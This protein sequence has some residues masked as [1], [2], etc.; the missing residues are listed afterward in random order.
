MRLLKLE[1]QGFG[2][3]KDYNEITFPE[4]IVGIVGQYDGNELQSNGSGKSTLIMAVIY[5]LFGEGEY[6]RLEELVN[7]HSDVKEMFV[8][9]HFSMNEI[10]YF[11]ERGRK[12]SSSYLDFKENGI[13]LGDNIKTTES[14]II[15]VVGMDYKMFTASVF[16]EQDKLDKFINVEPEER[17]SYVDKIL[18]LEIWRKLSKATK[19]DQK[20]LKDSIITIHANIAKLENKIKELLEKTKTRQSIENQIN[21]FKVEKDTAQK[22]MSEYKIYL[23]KASSLDTLRKEYQ[24]L[25]SDLNQITKNIL[26]CS[27]TKEKT[28]IECSELKEKIN[29]IVS[30]S[31]IENKIKSLLVDL[32]G[33]QTELKV[34]ENELAQKWET[35]LLHKNEIKILIQNRDSLVEGTC[36]TCFQSISKEYVHTK[37]DQ[38]QQSIDEASPVLEVQEKEYTLLSDKKMNL[39]NDI[40]S[41]QTSIDTLKKEQQDVE[42]QAINY[43]ASMSIYLNEISLIT[44]QLDS[45][46]EEELKLQSKVD[47]IK[48]EIETLQKELPEEMPSDEELLAKETLIKS[49]EEKI[50][51]LNQDLGELNQIEKEITFLNQEIDSAKSE[52]KQYEEDVESIS[53]LSD[54]FQEIPR[55]L[56]EQ[57]IQIIEESSNEMINQVFPHISVKIYEE[58]STKL[59]RLVVAF[60]VDGK[61]RNYKRLSGGEKAVVNIGLRLGFSK[62]IRLKS[63]TNI[64]FIV[65]DEPFGFLDEHNKN[66]IAKILNIV[67]DWFDQIIVISHVDKVQDFPKVINVRKNIEDVSYVVQ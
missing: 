61:E 18:D 66:L 28:E 8:R 60:D 27:D 35:I 59:K 2:S 3:Y 11:I 44:S 25:V 32:K 21:D 33:K 22:F 47:N 16:V 53:V 23:S 36:P 54:I 51:Q 31:D 13:R 63:K 14:E 48:K 9:L 55:Q 46:K 43:N 37:F 42:K 26:S 57:S 41:L 5:A 4:G 39:S 15:R 49:Y 64:G 6:T 56:F 1:L 52:I 65:L 7:D 38:L 29:S 34:T 19:S 12:G 24:V 45:F 10:V 40:E 50:L 30:T 58:E 62:V 17:R 20:K 67:L